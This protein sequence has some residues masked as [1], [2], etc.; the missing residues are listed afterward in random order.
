VFRVTWSH[1]EVTLG[2]PAL[3]PPQ[4]ACRSPGHEFR[5]A[6]TGTDPKPAVTRQ[7]SLQCWPQE[8]GS[9]QL[10]AP[11]APPPPPAAAALLPLPLPR[12]LKCNF[13]AI[14]NH[15]GDAAYPQCRA[16]AQVSLLLA[17]RPLASFPARSDCQ[18]SPFKQAAGLSRRGFGRSRKATLALPELA[19]ARL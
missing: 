10:P 16:D 19:P 3:P 12:A 14:E 1:V 17:R 7:E 8:R 5:E 4:P 13:T 9:R 11:V 6:S 2:S 18:K 15:N